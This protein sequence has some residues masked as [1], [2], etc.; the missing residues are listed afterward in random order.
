MGRRP[1]D[2][3]APEQ[4]SYPYASSP[5]L[6]AYGGSPVTRHVHDDPLRLSSPTRWLRGLGPIK[7]RR[8]TRRLRALDVRWLDLPEDEP[9]EH[10]PRS[11]VQLNATRP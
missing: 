5:A 3:F 7:H 8:V 6:P 10:V 9:R 2:V 11:A 1:A 4:M